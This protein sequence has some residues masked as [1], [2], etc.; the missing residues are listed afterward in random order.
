MDSEQ[1][2]ATNTDHEDRPSNLNLHDEPLPQVRFS[3]EENNKPVQLISIKP[4]VQ[5]D[6]GERRKES[7]DNEQEMSRPVGLS[8]YNWKNFLP[9]ARRYVREL[10]EE[11]LS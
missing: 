7:T 8:K 3:N 6:A 10:N 1:L 9:F 11:L 5:D 4:L 2:S